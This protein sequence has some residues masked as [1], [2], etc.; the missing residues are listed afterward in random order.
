METAIKID[1]ELVEK[2]QKVQQF[3]QDRFD[4]KADI[5][6]LLFIIGL[7][8]LG[9]KKNKFTKEQKTDLM[10][11]A[12]CKAA[13]FSGYFDVAH[14]DADGWPVWKQLKPLPVMNNKEQEI[15]IKAHIILYFESEGFLKS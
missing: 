1:K 10:N 6:E 14:L 4:K 3:M 5:K 7:R 11:L 15:F 12:F 9:Q 13:S 2:W 8:E